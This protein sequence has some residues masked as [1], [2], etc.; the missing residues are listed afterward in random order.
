[1]A[2]L[3]SAPSW[4]TVKSESES[5]EIR[6]AASV[7]RG[8]SVAWPSIVARMAAAL[9]QRHSLP[10]PRGRRRRKRATGNAFEIHDKPD[11]SSRRRRQRRLAG[12]TARASQLT[13]LPACKTL[14]RI[15]IGLRR[16]IWPI[17]SLSAARFQ[18]SPSARL[19][20]VVPLDCASVAVVVVVASN[21]RAEEQKA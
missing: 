18:R 17:Y 5:L 7:Q 19:V 21:P 10:P 14:T 9:G 15:Q 1:M 16:K 6:R 11:R 3:P 2:T 4:T 8:L 12:S 13:C 20:A